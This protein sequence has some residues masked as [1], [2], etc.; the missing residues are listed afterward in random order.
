MSF[1]F[2]NEILHPKYVNVFI[3]P[4]RYLLKFHITF[5][6]SSIPCLSSSG[7]EVSSLL[8]CVKRNYVIYTDRL[9]LVG[10]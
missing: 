7:N 6:S 1:S 4:I 3:C 2:S 5:S 10:Y 8:Y 9:L